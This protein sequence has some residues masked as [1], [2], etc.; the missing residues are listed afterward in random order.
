MKTFIT[1]DF[2][3]QSQTARELYHQHAKNQ[4]IYDYH[5]HIP[6]KLIAENHTFK[7]LYEIWLSGDHYKWR[8]MRS[9]GVAEKYCTGDASDFEKFLAFAKTV[10][11][12]LRNPMYHWTHLELLRYFGIDELLNEQSA[13]GIWEKANAQLA[14]MPVKEILKKSNVALIGTTDDPCDDLADHKKI[15]E[16]KGFKTRVYPS[17]RPDRALGVDNMPLFNAWVDK[18]S[19]AAD[20]ECSTF[21]GFVAAIKKRHDFFHENG[22]RLSDHGLSYCYAEDCTLNEARS[23]FDKARAGNGV[24]FAEAEKFRAY[25]MTLFGQWNAERGWV[26][27]LHLGPLRNNNTRLMKQIGP[28]TGFDSIGDFPQ[29]LALSRFLD[30]LDRTAQLPKTIL[31]NINPA[32]NYVIATMLGN[33]QDGS[34]PGKIQFG[35]G[36]WFMDQK[37]GM[38]WQINALSSLGLLSR[39]VGMLTDSRSF[40]S[41]SR[42]EYFRRILCNMI[43]NDVENGELPKDMS[44]LGSMVKGICFDNAK[45]YFGMPLA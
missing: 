30:R 37:E 20:M 38:Q 6:Q 16:D 33:F 27:Q 8:V 23:T 43:G 41:Y 10:P 24:D 15:R 5:C 1:D 7:N 11:M 17:F 35:S 26:M 4:P 45:E 42:H 14:K 3:L 2:L 36:W 18:L 39:F 21:D 34:V 44:L 32:D 13:K 19:Q 9:N 12:T 40:L 31:Y 29:G 28:D 25:M 22:C